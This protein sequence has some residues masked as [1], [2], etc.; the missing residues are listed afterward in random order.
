VETR[1][2]P[3]SRFAC[4][5]SFI[6]DTSTGTG[7]WLR[8]GDRLARGSSSSAGPERIHS[9]HPLRMGRAWHAP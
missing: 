1:L 2:T 8:A 9:E 5:D 4:I 6:F 7:S 3:L